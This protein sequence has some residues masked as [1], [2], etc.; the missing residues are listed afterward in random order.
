VD[1]SDFQTD[2]GGRLQLNPEYLQT[3]TLTFTRT[4]GGV[5]NTYVII[6]DIAP[7]VVV[8][9]G[10]YVVA[11]DAHGNATNNANSPGTPINS[12]ALA[13]LGLN[14]ALVG[15]SET[16]LILNS[17]GGSP[18]VNIPAYQIHGSGSGHRIIPLVAGDQLSMFGARSS[19]AGTTTEMI[20]NNQ[21]RCRITAWRIGTS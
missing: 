4:L 7:L 5:A 10:L 20:S 17:L 9:P 6:P 1:A 21:G 2:S 19:D 11:W 15:G 14:G 8:V 12:C 3:P 16:M 13:G 18:S